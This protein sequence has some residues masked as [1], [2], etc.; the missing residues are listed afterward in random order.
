MNRIDS[1]LLTPAPATRLATLRV[2]IVGYATAFLLA[3]SQSF[4]MGANLADRRIE[5]VGVLW[6]LTHRFDPT[7]A[8]AV[9]IVTIAIGMLATIGYRYRFTGP[10][11][12]ILFL[13]VATYRVSFGQVVHTE[14]LAAMHLLVI[15]FARA[16]DGHSTEEHERYGWPIRIMVLVTVITY[17]LAGWAKLEHGGLHWLV[18]DVLRNQVAYDNLRK[19][20]LGD[21]HS[22]IGAYIIRF[23]WLFPPFSIATVLVEIFAFVILLGRRRLYVVWALTAWA[24]HVG[25]LA[26]MAINFPYQVTFIAYAP[27]FRVERLRLAHIRRRL[28]R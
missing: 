13:L 26:T 6:W 28:D 15:G 5:G 25:V 7:L 18:G 12:A 22:P 9:F 2:L 16:A 19:V 11:F 24:F 3:R 23:P 21:L 10:T 20:L 27:L 17:T 14:H 4:W 8:H 1:W